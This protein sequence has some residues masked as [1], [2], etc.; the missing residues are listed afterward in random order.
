VEQTRNFNDNVY[1]QLNAKMGNSEFDNFYTQYEDQ[2]VDVEFDLP[3]DSPIEFNKFAI[4]ICMYSEN[5][6]FVPKIKDLRGIA[7]L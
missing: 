7:I 2:Y 5:A 6:A 1:V 3:V 4:K